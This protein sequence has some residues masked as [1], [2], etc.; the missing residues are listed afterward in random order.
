MTRFRTIFST[1]F[2]LTSFAT[3]LTPAMAETLPATERVG[4]LTLEEKA[5]LTTGQNAWQT[6]EVTRL[7]IP[8]AWMADG[9]VGL[10]KSTGENVTDSVPA[11]CFPSSAAMSATW[12]EDLVERLGFAIGAEARANDVSLLLAPGLNIKRHPLGGR[13]FEYYSED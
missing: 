5:A 13:N 2:V 10:R 8:A 7:G 4:E 3:S 12:N 11:T 6:F 1:A 9:P